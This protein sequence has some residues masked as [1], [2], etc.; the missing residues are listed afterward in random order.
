[1]SEKAIYETNI[2]PNSSGFGLYHY[3]ESTKVETDAMSVSEYLEILFREFEE[4]TIEPG[5]DDVLDK[6]EGGNPIG[7]F[8]IVKNLTNKD[9]PTYHLF[10]YH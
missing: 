1:M 7:D 8:A 4:D 3:G 9:F 10:E 6:I 2:I 5:E